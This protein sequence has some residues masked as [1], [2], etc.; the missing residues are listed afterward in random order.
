MTRY[1]KGPCIITVR[2]EAHVWKDKVIR[3]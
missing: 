3:Y 2:S 1:G